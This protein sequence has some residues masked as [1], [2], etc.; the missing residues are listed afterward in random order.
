MP[1]VAR[2]W[3]SERVTDFYELTCFKTLAENVAECHQW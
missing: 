3:A 2:D 1:K